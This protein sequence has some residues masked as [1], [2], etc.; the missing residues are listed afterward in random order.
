MTQ[1]IAEVQMD[2]QLRDQKV[3]DPEEVVF[4][5]IVTMEQGLQECRAGLANVHPPVKGQ[6]TESAYKEHAKG[7][8]RVLENLGS[9]LTTY[10]KK[11]HCY[12]MVNDRCVG[13]KK[14]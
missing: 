7:I 9:Q 2:L 5:N 12:R 8:E 4:H 1:C 10:D 11:L 3:S 14:K 6:I 13:C